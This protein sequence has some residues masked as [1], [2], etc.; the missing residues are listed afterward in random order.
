MSFQHHYADPDKI[1]GQNIRATRSLLSARSSALLK[2]A[3]S[4]V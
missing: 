3:T 2:E 1:E 4:D